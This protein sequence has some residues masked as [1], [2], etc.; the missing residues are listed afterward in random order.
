M[1]TALLEFYWQMESEIVEMQHYAAWGGGFLA[2][3]S[4]DLMNE[5]PDM[6][7]F[8]EENLKYICRWYL[9]YSGELSNS[10]TGCIQIT[11]G[12]LP[13]AAGDQK[14]AQLCPF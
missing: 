1:N 3:L 9:F 6:K 12:V 8:S 13:A 14:V 7:G 2:R 11:S 4:R 5:F 10:G